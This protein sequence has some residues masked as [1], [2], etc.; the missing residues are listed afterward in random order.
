MTL[1]ASDTALYIRPSTHPPDNLHPPSK[2]VYL[3]IACCVLGRPLNCR[4]TAAAAARPV[5]SGRLLQS[6]RTVSRT[7]FLVGGFAEHTRSAM[8]PG[9]GN[10]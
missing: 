7:D 4:Y 3:T 6:G 1:A 5:A 8:H 10:T 2:C 9:P